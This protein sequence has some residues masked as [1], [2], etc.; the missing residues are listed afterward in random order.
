MS[1]PAVCVAQHCVQACTYGRPAV[2]VAQHCVQACTYGRPAHLAKMCPLMPSLSPPSPPT[3]AVPAY[4]E[5][6]E[7]TLPLDQLLLEATTM[8]VP[9]S[10]Q[11]IEKLKKT[12]LA[13]DKTA[14]LKE[15]PAIQESLQSE[16][17]SA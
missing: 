7:P 17:C 6:E 1:R 14:F 3:L 13:L 15:L 4:A 5:E 2:C 8:A 16:P 12:F 10:I 11:G 9:S